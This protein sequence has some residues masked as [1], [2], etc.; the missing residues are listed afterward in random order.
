MRSRLYTRKLDRAPQGQCLKPIP[1]ESHVQ[2]VCELFKSGRMQADLSNL[3]EVL[4]AD[5]LEAEDLVRL[6]AQRDW[7]PAKAALQV[8]SSLH[9]GERTKYLAQDLPFERQVVAKVKRSR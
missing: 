4:N 9:D 1:S 5:A 6:R 3:D 2:V 8:L 7:Q